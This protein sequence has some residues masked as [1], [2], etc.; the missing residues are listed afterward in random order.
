MKTKIGSKE[1]PRNKSQKNTIKQN[2]QTNQTK[3]NKTHKQI[4]QTDKPE[5]AARNRQREEELVSCGL[6]ERDKETQAE[7]EIENK[8]A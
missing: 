3:P 2:L 4:R 8:R 7:R 1:K 6:E 5:V